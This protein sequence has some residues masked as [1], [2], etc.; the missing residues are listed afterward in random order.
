[1]K[2]LNSMPADVRPVP[3]I[4]TLAD[5]FRYRVTGMLHTVMLGD[6]VTGITEA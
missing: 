4:R 5:Y 6:D 3:M 2:S 1:M